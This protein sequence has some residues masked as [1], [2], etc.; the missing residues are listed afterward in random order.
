MPGTEEG[1]EDS[2]RYRKVNGVFERHIDDGCPL[3]SRS[4]DARKAPEFAADE[5]VESGTIPP[6][7]WRFP[8]MFPSR[9]SQVKV[10]K[11][12]T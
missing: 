8:T 2:G 5:D 7:T 9:G 4:D 11:V 10:K 1:S 3:V 6:G 12:P